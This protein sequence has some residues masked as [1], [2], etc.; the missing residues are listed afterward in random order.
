MALNLI[1]GGGINQWRDARIGAES[2]RRCWASSGTT[3][4]AIAGCSSSKRRTLSTKGPS[5]AAATN[6]TAA[7][8]SDLD[9]PKSAAAIDRR[10][11]AATT[12]AYDHSAQVV[13]TAANHLPWSNVAG[14]RLAAANAVDSGSNGLSGCPWAEPNNRTTTAGPNSSGCG[15]RDGLVPG[16]SQRTTPAAAATAKTSNGTATA[17]ASTASD[18]TPA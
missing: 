1:F 12:T 14:S 7:A 4:A 3:S 9:G 11:A 2:L 8:S 16:R 10:P 15:G 13:P 18:A 6:S 5:M 17:T